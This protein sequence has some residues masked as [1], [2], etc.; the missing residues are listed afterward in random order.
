M[1]SDT[2]CLE[3]NVSRNCQTNTVARSVQ[4][5]SALRS[6]VTR[7]RHAKK[8]GNVHFLCLVQVT[9]IYIPVE[10]TLL[11]FVLA[12]KRVPRSKEEAVLCKRMDRFCAKLYSMWS[13]VRDFSENDK[14]FR[15][16]KTYVE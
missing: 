16:E 6:L 13:L 5:R 9:R 11:G 7:R 1:F 4:S 3:D 15:Q 2:C 8:V 12:N 10:E 14:I